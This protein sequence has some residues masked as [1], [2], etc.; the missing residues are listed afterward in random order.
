MDRYRHPPDAQERAR[1][2][3]IQALEDAIAFRRAR[4]T[5]GC[6]DCGLDGTPCDDH[7]CDLMLVADYRRSLAALANGTDPGVLTRG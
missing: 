4:A 6:L 5:E 7:A 2:N 1:L 3:Y